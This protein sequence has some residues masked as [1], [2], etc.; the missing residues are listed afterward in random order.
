MDEV[1][2]VTTPDNVT[3]AMLADGRRRVPATT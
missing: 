3:L 1:P 2:F